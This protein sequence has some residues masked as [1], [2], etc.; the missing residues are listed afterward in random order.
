MGLT[1]ISGL[2]SLELPPPPS[3]PTHLRSRAW[4]TSDVSRGYWA[5][6]LGEHR[7]LLGDLLA[8]TTHLPGKLSI[9]RHTRADRVLLKPGARNVLGILT[10]EQTSGRRRLIRPSAGGEVILCSGVFETPRLL[11]SLRASPSLGQHLQD[12]SMLPVIFVGNRWALPALAGNPS[13]SVHGWVNLDASGVPVAADAI[14]TVQLL[15]I[16]GHTS[17]DLIPHL[18]L[19]EYRGPSLYNNLLRPALQKLLMFLLSWS[20]LRYLLSFTFGVGVCKVRLRGEGR[21]GED[22]APGTISPLA[23]IAGAVTWCLVGFPVGSEDFAAVAAGLD[24]A[25]RIV[26]EAAQRSK[27]WYFELLPG[28]LFSGWFRGYFE[29]FT[30]SYYHCC[31]TCRMGSGEE[32]M[33]DEQLRVRGVCGLRVADASVLPTIP[34][35][36]IAAVCMAIGVRAA[37]ELTKE[38]S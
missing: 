17:R 29:L 37:V 2:S 13:N 6:Y 28:P 27:L 12:H 32:D 25:R 21:L 34:S 38:H 5:S 14:P 33:V 10:T 15:F 9:L 24:T 26:R 8:D 22:H 3:T 18:L 4:D 19:P 16:D 36:P 11:R 31:G 35:G 30:M 23:C 1:H 20:F 7:T